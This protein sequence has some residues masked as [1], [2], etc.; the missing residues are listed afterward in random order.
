[1]K[2]KWPLII[3][4]VVTLMLFRF[5]FSLK[6]F[7]VD[8]WSNAAWG[9]W[10]ANNGSKDF[11]YNNVWV[12]SWPTQLP[13]INLIY[14]WCFDLGRYLLIDFI[15]LG[16]LME[17][18]G[19]GAGVLN[20]YG[21][22]VTFMGSK[23]SDEIPFQNVF[24]FSIKLIPIITD[25]IIAGII[26]LIGKDKKGWLWGL[27]YLGSPFAWYTSAFWGQYDQLSFLMLLLSILTLKKFR[28]LSPIFM[29]LSLGVKPTSAIFI[30]FYLLMM[31]EERKFWKEYL[32]GGVLGL[33]VNLYWVGLFSKEESL[34]NFIRGRL[35]SMV[36]DKSEPRVTVN[37]Y[38]FWHLFLG[39]KAANPNEFFLFLPYKIWGLI[40][41]IWANIVGI[42][43]YR[44]KNP[45]VLRTTF[46]FTGHNENVWA[47]LS[48]VGIGCWLF[49]MNMLER[50]LFSGVVFGLI[51][52]IFYKKIRWPVIL[53]SL[54]F[55]VNLYKHWWQPAWFDLLRIF[56]EEYGLAS[57][58]LTPMIILVAFGFM[59]KNLYD[60]KR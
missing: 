41:M 13:L 38:N 22:F 18:L 32:L 6:Y 34:I 16:N 9:E 46:P 7:H 30:P 29:S 54:M 25:L 45:L 15:R 49:G 14:S 51:G 35:W 26:G 39:D 24:L 20:E 48:V 4:G 17:K 59:I 52:C 3:L 1:M 40:G 60:K 23:Y 10:I 37:S 50:Y 53:I 11:F 42:K 21:K 44:S 19:V 57:Q 36:I 8:I 28:I 58:I 47:A 55:F 33:G 31:W 5:Y 12:Y 56:H 43:I 27:L 2:R